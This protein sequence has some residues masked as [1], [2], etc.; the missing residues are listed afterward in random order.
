MAAAADAKQLSLSDL[1]SA[2]VRKVLQVGSEPAQ[3]GLE[4]SLVSALGRDVVWEALLEACSTEEV[5]LHCLGAE[6]EHVQPAANCETGLCAGSHLMKLFASWSRMQYLSLRWLPLDSLA[7]A[8]LPA[9]SSLRVL[10]LERCKL[11][12]GTLTAVCSVIQSLSGLESLSLA[13]NPLQ[14]DGVYQ[15]MAALAS[16]GARLVE[17]SLAACSLSK[18]RGSSLAEWLHHVPVASAKRF[19]WATSLRELNLS[20]NKLGEDGME[21]F[22]TLLAATPQLR[23]LNVRSNS[24][25]YSGAETLSSALLSLGTLRELDIGG[26]RFNAQCMEGLGGAIAACH[27]QALDLSNNPLDLQGMAALLTCISPQSPCAGIRRLDLSRCKLKMDAAESVATALALLG[28]LTHLNISDNKL[29]DQ[30]FALIAG[31]LFQREAQLQRLD[32]AACWLSD[33]SAQQFHK[34]IDLN[35]G[36]RLKL[37]VNKFTLPV[38]STLMRAVQPKVPASDG[39]LT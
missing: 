31:A 35:P 13:H 24:L 25:G 38:Q 19:S 8:C 36:I 20:S 33:A 9:T 26:N 18:V 21:S 6:L 11:N 23:S 4:P 5:K 34:L 3:E 1:R 39:G 10:E 12:S 32:V 7:W 30:G 37:A 16:S 22:A 17:L 29:C 27:L 15:V 28:H 2:L 14:P